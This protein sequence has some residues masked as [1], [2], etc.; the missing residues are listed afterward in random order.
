MR[1]LTGFIHPTATP[2]FVVIL[3][4]QIKKGPAI[5]VMS[6]KMLSTMRWTCV[7]LEFIY[8]LRGLQGTKI[9]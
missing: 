6:R 5:L 4:C 7:S 2:K 1:M 8:D 9:K 3:S